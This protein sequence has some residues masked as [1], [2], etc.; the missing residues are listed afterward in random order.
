MYST[1]Y[2]I[3]STEMWLGFLF[4]LSIDDIYMNIY[5]R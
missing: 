2:A 3:K 4:N 1:K 5:D